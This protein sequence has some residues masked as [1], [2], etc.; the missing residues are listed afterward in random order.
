MAT[1]IQAKNV[2]R[3]EKDGFIEVVV[4]L[5]AASTLQ[6]SVEYSTAGRTA[7]Y[8]YP[9]YDFTFT[10][11]KLVFAPGVV[12]QTIR[13]PVTDDMIA[14]G[15]EFLQM[16]FSSPENAVIVN[17]EV[18]LGIIDNDVIADA[19][20]RA[21]LSVRDVVVD[22]GAGTA[23]FDVVLDKA[24]SAPFSVTYSTRNGTALAGS[25]YTAASGSLT[26]AAGETVKQ[27]VV[28]LPPRGEAEFAE[29][30]D[31]VLGNL[32]GSGAGVVR[33]ADGSGEA[34]IGRNGQTPVAT[35][36]VS[37]S[38]P[39]VSE[40]DGYVDFVVTLSAP[41]LQQVSVEYAT[42]GVYADYGYPDYDFDFASGT[43]V[44]APGVTTQTVRVAISND[45]LA[46]VPETFALALSSPVN[47]T[48]THPFGIATIVD[49]DTLGSAALRAQLSVSDVIV[50]ASADYVTF[51][52]TL[53]K[54]V[55]G[56]FSVAYGTADGNAVA[57]SDYLAA[58]G[59]LTFAPGETVKNVT[60]ALPHDRSA[61]P[62]ELF[63]LVLGAVSGDAAGVVTVGDGSGQAMIGRHGQ[64][65]VATPTIYVSNPVAGEKDG[66]VEFV[67]S[68][69]A[70]AVAQVSVEF[71]TVG[72]LAD[73][74]YPD[75]DFAYTSG[76]LVFA[77]GQTTQVVRVSINDD[78][79]AEGVENFAL[80]LSS[81]TNAVIAHRY[82]YATLFDNDT[83]ADAAHRAVLSVQDLVIDASSDLA[84]F[85]ISLDKAV[86]SNFN[87]AY[88][89]VG[90]S[91]AAGSDFLDTR[92]I[93]TFEAGETV[94]T[95]SVV[96]PHDNAA[97]AAETFKLAL[98]AVSG[99]GAGHVVVGHAT[100]TATIG[101]HG[102][103]P[104]SRPTININDPVARESDGYI[105]FVVTLGAPSSTQ[106]SVDYN[107]ANGTASY[108]YPNYD[109]LYA[110]GTLVFAPG[111]TT[112]TVRVAVNADML[113]EG[114]ESIS[115]KL[116]DAVNG[117][118]AKT[119]GV[120][121]IIDTT[122]WN[123]V[124]GSSAVDTVSYQGPRSN[125]TVSASKDGYLVAEKAAG[126][127][128]ELVV[129]VERLKFA[130]TSIGLDID[131]TGGQAYRIYQ[132]A[133][134]R[135]PDAGG[136]GFWLSA[137]DKGTTLEE[138]AAGFMSSPEFAKLYGANPSNRDLV[139]KIYTNVLHRAAE[140]GGLDYWSSA[141]DNKLVTKAQVLAM[142]SESAENQ[143]AVLKVIADGFP[144]TPYG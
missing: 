71:S 69:S 105:E 76:K 10:S 142:I 80:S 37:V 35:P 97:E 114:N 129:G 139:S 78:N 11:G 103:S 5:S 44:F 85:T 28:T 94:K 27:V 24:A 116:S 75:Y 87:I 34:I 56:S 136:L 39:V 2:L 108:G 43:L 88:G 91:A 3:S 53:D 126:G 123:Q 106:V 115:L 42:R 48:V 22:A 120:A 125:Y 12:T 58:S 57:G 25:D 46:E 82:G 86:S 124:T 102:Q 54:A 140:Q 65:A 23:V 50:D 132:A 77:P 32:S 60:V 8:G 64:T 79:L 113:S 61:E 110:S 104:V 144:Y 20:N 130:D 66:V 41:G 74:G 15:T 6:V 96:L 18:M 21:N 14:E 122:T 59:V 67:V 95:V 7:G 141:L 16:R 55:T 90:G 30:F 9:D 117:T 119:A 135:T 73:Y 33:I 121:T 98:G 89:T 118:I 62:V 4:T 68:L 70:P 109:Y 17:A 138:V 40:A 49:N 137:M 133:F 99:S 45:N 36:M 1:Y 84:T 72:M 29:M 127:R 101:A 47:A 31:L 83:L 13:V 63:N 107:T 128:V 38:N 100:G 81:P 112:Q 93:L 134:D 143:E 111:V 19:A 51:A 52:V 131:G 26:F 92:G